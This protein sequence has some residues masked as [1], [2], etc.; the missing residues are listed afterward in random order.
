[1]PGSGSGVAILA[2]VAPS[3]SILGDD[4]PSSLDAEKASSEDV[5]EEPEAEEKNVG[6][7]DDNWRRNV[8]VRM[9]KLLVFDPVNKASLPA[10]VA[11]ILVIKRAI[12]DATRIVFDIDE[13][14][15]EGISGLGLFQSYGC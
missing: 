7:D 2:L 10:E 14:I 5:V 6:V 9:F 4:P 8:S 13:L 15:N 3:E 11:L 12:L 1:M